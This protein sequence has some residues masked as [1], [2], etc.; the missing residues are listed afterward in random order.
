MVVIVAESNSYNP[1][2]C[3]L[4]GSSVRGISQARILEWVAKGLPGFSLLQGIVPTR[5]SNLH[6][7]HWQ[8]DSLPLSHQ[9]SLCRESTNM[10][11]T[12]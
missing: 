1:K 3:S 2:D 8:V 7:I 6:L 4:P 11:N 5:G 10:R 12:A 9:G